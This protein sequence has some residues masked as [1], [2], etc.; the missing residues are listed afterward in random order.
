MIALPQLKTKLMD[1]PFEKCYLLLLLTIYVQ[2]AI[3]NKRNKRNRNSFKWLLHQSAAVTPLYRCTFKIYNGSF[4]FRHIGVSNW[5]CQ[6]LRDLSS[7]ARI[8]P[9]VLQ[10][11]LIFNPVI[12]NFKNIVMG[13]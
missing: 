2:S 5:S 1:Q 4:I 3:T 9:A 13:K 11:R 8:R 10:V 7:F 6:G 12:L